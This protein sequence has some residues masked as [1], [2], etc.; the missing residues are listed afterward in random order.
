MS[1]YNRVT[2][3]ELHLQWKSNSG[4]VCCEKNKC[5]KNKI[6][7]G[8]TWTCIS[9]AVPG[10]PDDDYPILAEVPETSFNCE[11]DERQV[12]LFIRNEYQS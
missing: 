12:I 8:L 9:M 2:S 5:E 10:T 11:G 7:V 3:T 6:S 4:L 1:K